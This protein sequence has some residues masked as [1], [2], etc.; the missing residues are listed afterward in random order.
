VLTA[1]PRRPTAPT[2]AG[3]QT[4]A[5]VASDGE[6]EDDVELDALDQ[7][8]S[9]LSTALEAAD[10]GDPALVGLDMQ[11]RTLSADAHPRADAS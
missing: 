6:D 7:A 3:V 2:R 1:P 8:A 11:A 5:E 10:G 4:A 9:D